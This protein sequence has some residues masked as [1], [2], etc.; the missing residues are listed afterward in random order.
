MQKYASE[1]LSTGLIL[2]AS[3][4]LFVDFSHQSVQ[5]IKSKLQESIHPVMQAHHSIEKL[6]RLILK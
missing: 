5:F 3:N 4:Q 6:Q 1:K 2:P